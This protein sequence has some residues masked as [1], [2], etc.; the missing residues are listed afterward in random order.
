MNE[1]KKF[2]DFYKIIIKNGVNFYFNENKNNIYIILNIENEGIY[3]TLKT[4][5]K[6][7]KDVTV[8]INLE[9]FN[10]K[11]KIFIKKDE[12]TVNNNNILERIKD[13]FILFN[14]EYKKIW[15]K[16]II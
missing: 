11:D 13:F 14:V 4:K 1:N 9:E 5:N 8:L 12:V 16:Y 6:K 2:I 15:R 10:K 3:A 7:E